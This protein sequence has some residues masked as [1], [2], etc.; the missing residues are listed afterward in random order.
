LAHDP[1]GLRLWLTGSIA[2]QATGG[3]T[4]VDQ[5]CPPR[6]GQEAERARKV[7]GKDTSQ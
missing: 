3:S 4:M 7:L 6:G 1:R 5:G 2:F